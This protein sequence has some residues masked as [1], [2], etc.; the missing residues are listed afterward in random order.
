MKKIQITSIVFY[1][2][3][4]LAKEEIKLGYFN[5]VQTIDKNIWKIK[6]HL[7][8]T[9]EIIITPDLFFIT[10]YSFP[11]TEILGFEKYLKKKLYNQRIHDV[12]Q[13]KNNK[14]MALKLDAYYLIFEFFSKSNVI[15]TDLDFKIIT[16]KQKEEWKDR[17]IVKGEIYKFPQGKEFLENENLEKEIE[18]MGKKEIIKHLSKNYNIAPI[19]IDKIIEENK[20]LITEIKKNYLSKKPG[21]EKIIKK[22]IENYIFKESGLDIFKTFQEEFKKEYEKKE[23]I[24]EN[25]KKEKI[26]EI[27]NSQ[28][29]KKN[30]FLEKINRL[31][32]EGE[33]IYENFVIIDQINKQIQKALEKGISVKEIIER[34]NNYFNK[35]KI[36]LE[37]IK[38]N[39]KEKEYEIIKKE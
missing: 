6:I 10:D 7:K 25:K 33:F 15:L 39:Q 3:V 5:N 21:M 24:T 16:S 11:V 13:D 37:I 35:N 8:R 2:L 34:I 22:D 18:G 4:K 12:F 23:V 36:K 20:N 1:H 38:I 9:K 32:K 26:K 17:S 14:V 19:E 30:T 28:K 29:N 27:L 31:E